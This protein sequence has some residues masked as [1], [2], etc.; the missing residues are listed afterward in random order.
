MRLKLPLLIAI[1]LLL[2]LGLLIVI[3]LLLQI[4]RLAVSLPRTLETELQ[5]SLR[6]DI[7]VRSA[8]LTSPG[9]IVVN[10][11]SIENRKSFGG[12][13]LFYA[14][15]VVV[16]FNTINVLLRRGTLARNITEVTI[17]D[18]RLRLVRNRQG[19]WNI[20]DLVTRPPAPP[21]E[22]F[23]G[24]VSVRS[25][26]LIVEDYAAQLPRLPAV[27]VLEDV[28]STL[29]FSPMRWATL[30]IRGRGAQG[31]VDTVSASGRWGIG[32][33]TTNTRITVNNA[34]ARYWF[35]YFSNIRN[36]DIPSGNADAVATL[37]QPMGAGIVARGSAVLRNASIT[38]PYMRFP[39]N[40]FAAN[41]RFIGTNISLAGQGFLRRSPVWIKGYILGLAP[42]R[43]D[44]A[45]TS[46]RMDLGALQADLKP[47]PAIPR[48]RW[49][50]PG[51]ISAQVTGFAR[52]PVV[53]ARISVP[54]ATVLG[55]PLSSVSARGFYRNGVIQVTRLV[56]R[57]SDGNLNMTA[58]LPIKPFQAMVSGTASG[59]NLSGLQTVRGL[60]IAGI[61]NARF[62][63]QYR[64]GIRSAQISATVSRGRIGS[65]AFT[66]G[67]ANIIFTGP[68][69]AS[70]V[71]NITQ[72]TAP[73]IRIETARVDMAL[74]GRNILVRQIEVDAFRG[75]ITAN[76]TATTS[77]DLTLRVRADDAN[78]SA[79]LAP[80][81]YKQ[82]TGI[83]DFSGNL[84][85][86]ISNPRLAGS[87]IARNGTLRK[88]RYD[89][90]IGRMIA[91]PQV[92][93]LENAII[94]R[95]QTEVIL[96]GRITIPRRAPPAAQVQVT[97]RQVNVSELFS[98]LGIPIQASG[99]A[100][101]NIQVRGTYP[102]LLVSGEAFLNNAV[103]AGIAV[104]HAVARF[105]ASGGRTVITELFA[106]RG[107][108]RMAGSGFVG[109][110]GRLQ[111][112][113][114]GENLSLSL[115]DRIVYPYVQ[116]QGSMT[117]NGVVGGTIARPVFN[118]TVSSTAPIINQQQF[119]SFVARFL[120]DGTCLVLNDAVL[121]GE[122][123]RYSISTLVFTPASRY[124]AADAS[125]ASGYITRIMSMVK[126]SPLAVLPDG[127]RL[128]Q[129]MASLPTPF[130]GRFSAN[131]SLRGPIGDIQGSAGIAAEG[132]T[133]GTSV[134]DRADLGFVAQRSLFFL[135]RIDVASSGVALSASGTFVNALP[136]AVSANLTNTQV[137]P[138]LALIQNAPFLSLYDFG[139]SLIRIARDIPKP[140]TGTLDANLSVANIQTEPTGAFTA[141]GTGVAFADTVLGE[142]IANGRLVAGTVY[143]D[144][145]D[146]SPQGGQAVASGTISREGTIALTGTG[147][148]MPLN[149][150]RPFVN[151]PSLSG[152]ANFT[153]TARGPVSDPIITA[154]IVASNVGTQRATIDTLTADGIV[155]GNGRLTFERIIAQKD[156]SRLVASGFLPFSWQSPFIPETSP[157]GIQV[158]L[159]DENL[160]IARSLFP[161][162]QAASGTFAANVFI[163]GTYR[164]PIF[165]GD[166]LLRN[167]MLNLNGFENDFSNV[168][169]TARF[170]D[171]SL[172]IGILT[173]AS[174][175]GGTFSAN[176]SISFPTLT[177]GSLAM[178]VSLNSL[179]LHVSN[180]TGTIGEDVTFTTIG[181]LILSETLRSPLISGT[182]VVRDAG[183]LLPARQLPTTVAIP[184]LP[185]NPQ[186]AI[187]LKLA[188]N[189][190]VQ[191]GGLTAE[192]I[193]PVTIA[194]S[195]SSPL[196][197]GTLQIVRGSLRYANRTL[198]IQPGG[199]ISLL[200]R[201]P[202]SAVI[203]V[204]L[205]A[206]TRASIVSPLTGRITRY[207][208]I[209]EASGPIGDLTINVRSIPP[210]LSDIEVLSYLF[211]GAALDAIVGGT[212]SGQVLQ[213]EI[214]QLLLGFAIPGLFQP[215]EIGGISI[216]L[217]PGITGPFAIT[218]SANLTDRFVLSYT[219][220]TT[221][222]LPVESF[223]FSYI[224]GPQFAI[225]LEFGD[226]GAGGEPSDTTFFLEYYNRF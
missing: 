62:N 82:V 199:I 99:I 68:Q 70:A 13:T 112:A 44:L 88:V 20:E 75:V 212:P 211:G 155:I 194:G 182:L 77:G 188:N 203:V 47:I 85:G 63:L 12:G 189:V 55:V 143:L 207:T 21:A 91:T 185:V 218:A 71:L 67:N 139:R 192:I 106:R 217:E 28:S 84:T 101:A 4:R 81:G 157:V 137:S 142:V 184:S 80:L 206:S 104:D 35:N 223:T 165:A 66:R 58:R 169:M 40:S 221:S 3:G 224:L 11:L 170:E 45:I 27:N 111:I 37:Y 147:T 213:N 125:I 59:I 90:L 34:D 72:G 93:V 178:T 179:R 196:I 171:S 163:A 201:S 120:W 152:T 177:I 8:R 17:L 7:R 24:L 150:L 130:S 181:Q 159:V 73:G 69:T 121:I 225:A 61:A 153:F 204:D 118:G 2:I 30:S 226:L 124:F 149:L 216:G 197:S 76:G 180:L 168:E 33:P 9:T 26:R 146:L 43:V 107:D 74:R 57:A 32:A 117:F 65:L 113:L 54:R 135:N 123:T 191:R 175:L 89:L 161:S 122:D 187:T 53:T 160:S 46:T 195:A 222:T 154:S 31:R 127:E 167:G 215:I 95:R 42:S 119:D 129:I 56:G 5:A 105:T 193:G 10:G 6:R 164:N 98:I 209:M 140:A 25:G 110:G 126:N 103:I 96:A 183:I 79:L 114:T 172:V 22:R 131:L 198:E 141:A 133:L 200:L 136:T 38:S 39:I 174:S 173:G 220:S 60:P 49:P 108:M 1:A 190:I 78:L 151:I 15:Q 48:T 97:T 205:T 115:L 148:N 132:V 156:T 219:R 86:T 144:Q 92:L 83:A 19:V 214:G 186:L 94:R 36:W 158:S 210:G 162:I 208:I 29:N 87:V 128:R 102:N 41:A 64:Q 176:G 14:R 16:H 51:S 116:L 23:R 52:D 202:Q 109:P 50:T 138:L 18:P 134:V 166:A 100:S 145:L